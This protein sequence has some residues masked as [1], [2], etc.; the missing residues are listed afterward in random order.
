MAGCSTASSHLS[1]APA[2]LHA[3]WGE[4][5]PA[6]VAPTLRSGV[7]TDAAVRDPS[8]GVVAPLSDALLTVPAGEPATEFTA[9]AS[10]VEES[11]ASSVGGRS[12]FGVLLGEFE[13]YYGM[14]LDWGVSF[15]SSHAPLN[16]VGPYFDVSLLAC[17]S[18]ALESYLADFNFGARFSFASFD[19]SVAPYLELGLNV[20][21][22]SVRN[23]FDDY[24]FV[25]SAGACA[26]VG[27][28]V[29][30][31]RWLGLNIDWRLRFVGTESE[32]MGP[33]DGLDTANLNYSR[34][35]VGLSMGS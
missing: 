26:G 27:L 9:A 14:D 2:E 11:E 31:N 16:Q 15:G 10:R 32:A 6:T 20:I 17:S 35:F 21:G 8:C 30:P 19:P 25:A 18:D 12:R 29:R 1:V 23:D 24:W 13:D 34:L 4:L 28:D 33:S 5:G 7:A 22:G 3:N